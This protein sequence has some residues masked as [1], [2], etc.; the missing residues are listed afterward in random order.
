MTQNEPLITIITSVYNGEK[1]LRECIESVLKQDYKN[2]EYIIVNDGSS[3]KSKQIINEYSKKDT[4][5]KAIHKENSGVSNSRNIALQKASGEFI[6]L[7]DQDDILATN[8]VSYFYKLI[9]TYNTDIAITLS[10]QKFFRKEPKPDKTK[11][12]I[13]IFNGEQ[14]AIMMLYHKMVIAPWNKMISRKLIKENNIIFQPQFFNGEGFAFSIECFMKAT[15]VAIGHK[16]IYYYRVGDPNS[17]ASKFKEEWIN[18]SINAQQYIKTIL[19][20]P[21][22]DIIKAWKFSNWHTHCD[23]LNVIIGCKAKSNHYM[24]YQSIKNTCQKQ[25]LC[26]LSAPI[27]FQQK[28]R[29]I[30][31]KTNPYIAAQIINFFRK[32]KF[33]E[34]DEN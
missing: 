28:L 8:Y 16:K 33:K 22:Q 31:F 26:A 25:A 20:S 17:G 4:R 5:I 2:I 9:T 7:L 32:R 30:L 19:N 1:Y 34:E 18:S 14:V 13:E 15:K 23:A 12:K 27:S 10:P 6:C 11:D 3:D 24:L 21:N 29:G